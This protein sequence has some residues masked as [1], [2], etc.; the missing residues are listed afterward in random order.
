MY[1]PLNDQEI[2]QPNLNKSTAPMPSEVQK[3]QLKT[4][5]LSFFTSPLGKNAITICLLITAI[6][7]MEL[8]WSGVYAW[9][10]STLLEHGASGELSTLPFQLSPIISVIVIPIAGWASDRVMPRAI[11]YGYGSRRL[12]LTVTILVCCLAT[13]CV[14]LTSG[15]MF[16]QLPDR[17]I[18][19]SQLV[20]NTLID[21]TNKTIESFVRAMISTV[22]DE[23]LEEVSHVLMTA[24]IGGS[25]ILGFQAT[26]FQVGEYLPVG[27]TMNVYYPI[28]V[29]IFLVTSLPLFLSKAE[30]RACRDKDAKSTAAERP[31]DVPLLPVTGPVEEVEGVAK[32]PAHRTRTSWG[33]V[34]GVLVWCML[35]FYSA[36]VPWTFN[37]QFLGYILFQGDPHAPKGSTAYEQ[38]EQG[39]GFAGTSDSIISIGT[40]T[41]VATWLILDAVMGRLKRVAKIRPLLLGAGF[42]VVMFI[43]LAMNAFAPNIYV[44]VAAQ[45]LMGSGFGAATNFV[46]SR[47]AHYTHIS[48]AGLVNTLVFSAET[49]PQML[50]TVSG[51]MAVG[52]T[53]SYRVPYVLGMAPLLVSIPLTFFL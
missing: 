30:A 29:A 42:N 38:Y 40:L 39:A 6:A 3:H 37:P 28:G 32:P 49:L 14:P 23:R 52:L 47:A 11:R 10:T 46:F 22:A 2:E 34:V 53:G 20:L 43:G 13:L 35:V 48:D 26:S 19:V 25:M 16:P 17:F 18:L 50:C 21:F 45:L 27:P 5:F 8:A 44:F 51:T 1:S 9:T 15:T 7:G 33:Q 12:I 36:W 24:V 41:A 31:K 4:T